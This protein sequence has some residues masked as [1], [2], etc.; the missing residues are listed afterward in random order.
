MPVRGQL[1]RPLILSSYTTPRDLTRAKALERK[2]GPELWQQALVFAP[3][4]AASTM[5]AIFGVWSRM[6]AQRKW[7]VNC[8]G[9]A[10]GYL[11]QILPIL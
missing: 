10:G 11:G 4:A 2:D 3:L 5:L 6:T 8:P 1:P 9:F 7:R